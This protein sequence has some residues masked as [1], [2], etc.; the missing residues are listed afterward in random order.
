MRTASNLLVPIHATSSASSPSHGVSTSRPNA[1]R[2]V[3]NTE[4]RPPPKARDAPPVFNTTSAVF[5]CSSRVDLHRLFIYLHCCCMCETAKWGQRAPS[6]VSKSHFFGCS[7]PLS[8]RPHRPIGAPRVL[9]RTSDV[10]CRV[11]RLRRLKREKCH[12]CCHV[13][14]S[15]SCRR[16]QRRR[17]RRSKGRSCSR[18]ATGT[19]EESTQTG[20]ASPSSAHAPQADARARR[21]NALSKD[22]NSA[23]GRGVL[24][25]LNTGGSLA[26]RAPTSVRPSLAR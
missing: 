2:V 20:C 21:S 11:A 3:T 19:K 1:P 15:A 24:C 7:A 22:A 9:G 10:T 14:A 4:G 17:R 16:R 12:S 5:A 18:P 26:R 13:W 23:E 6:A 25:L 8:H